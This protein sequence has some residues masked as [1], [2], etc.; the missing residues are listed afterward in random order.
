M[1]MSGR[2]RLGSASDDVA[3]CL[4]H[5]YNL[6]SRPPT[7]SYLVSLDL[8]FDANFGLCAMFGQVLQHLQHRTWLM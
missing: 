6:G 8:V 1:R 2:Q 3:A 4:H 5:V 7:W